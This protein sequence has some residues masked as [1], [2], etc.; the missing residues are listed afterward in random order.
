M[1]TGKRAEIRRYGLVQ[2]KFSALLDRL[3][4]NTGPHPGKDRTFE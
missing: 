3:Y 2:T 1:S 4:R